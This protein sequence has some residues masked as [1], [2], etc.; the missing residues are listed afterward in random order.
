MVFA[1][2]VLSLVPAQRQQS[3]AWLWFNMRGNMLAPDSEETPEQRSDQAIP[4]SLEE[5]CQNQS[6]QKNIR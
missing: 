5:W 1:C 2:T 6:L 3:Y 4:T